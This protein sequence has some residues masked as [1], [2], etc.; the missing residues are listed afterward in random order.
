MDKSTDNKHFKSAV[1]TSFESHSHGRGPTYERLERDQ[2]HSKLKWFFSACQLYCASVWACVW[3]CASVFVCMSPQSEVFNEC[4]SMSHLCL[5]I[6]NANISS[7]QWNHWA[8]GTHRDPNRQTAQTKQGMQIR[9]TQ[10]CFCSY[11]TVTEN[12]PLS[13]I[14]IG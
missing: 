9:Q 12:Y 1:N 5:L 11:P 7:A 13:V 6:S 2:I 14:N 8:T 3:M 4:W 10:T